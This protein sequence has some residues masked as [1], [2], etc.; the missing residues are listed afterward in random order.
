M[1]YKDWKS[2]YLAGRKKIIGNIKLSESVK[3]KKLIALQN[4][5]SAI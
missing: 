5:R 1:T 2:K 4:K 3:E